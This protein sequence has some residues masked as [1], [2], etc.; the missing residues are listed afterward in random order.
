MKHFENVKDDP[1]EEE[2]QT[3][4]YLNPKNLEVINKKL[5]QATLS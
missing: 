3:D 1:K 2:K 4:Q 5:I